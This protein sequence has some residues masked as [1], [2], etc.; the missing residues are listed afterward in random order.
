M[1][2]AWAKATRFRVDVSEIGSGGITTQQHSCYR[3]GIVWKVAVRKGIVQR[4][5][6]PL[7]DRQVQPAS[8]ILSIATTISTVALMTSRDRSDN[9]PPFAPLPAPPVGI[10]SSALSTAERPC[11]R[12]P[13]SICQALSRLFPSG[14]VCNT[15]MIFTAPLHHPL[16]TTPSFMRTRRRWRHGFFPSPGL[17]SSDRFHRLP[18][19]QKPSTSKRRVFVFL[20]KISRA[21]ADST[22]VWLRPSSSPTSIL[23]M[24]FAGR[25]VCRQVLAPT[26]QPQPFGDGRTIR[27]VSRPRQRES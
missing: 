6:K 19:N 27:A 14:R 23:D 26:G 25:Y 1:T 10:V 21:T 9:W 22:D 3:L 24:V 11:R 12:G 18:V 8:F 15:S 13:C 7:D 17:R 4:D 16:P 5:A 20:K 2:A